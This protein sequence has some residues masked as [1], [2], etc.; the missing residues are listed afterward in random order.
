VRRLSVGEL[1]I[2]DA[3]RTPENR[4]VDDEPE[5]RGSLITIAGNVGHFVAF[6][7]AADTGYTFAAIVLLIPSNYLANEGL[8]AV[9][10]FPSRVCPSFRV[11]WPRGLA[12]GKSAFAAEQAGYG[13]E[14]G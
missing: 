14:A 1:T 12:V 8:H 3:L 6:A 7:L 2:T 5:H 13:R 11:C 9:I 4:S 10:L